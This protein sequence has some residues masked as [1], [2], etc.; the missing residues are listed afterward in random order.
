MA[1]RTVIKHFG[2]NAG[3][4]PLSPKG[5][6][7][8]PGASVSSDRPAGFT[9]LGLTPIDFDSIDP[10]FVLN[11]K[12]RREYLTKYLQDRVAEFG[13]QD[14]DVSEGTP[15]PTMLA[16]SFL[17]STLIEP[18]VI[19]KEET[20]WWLDFVGWMLG[21]P[22]KAEDVLRT[23]WLDSVWSGGNPV[24]DE[25]SVNLAM[26][27][28]DI[29][30]FVDVFVH[31]KERFAEQKEKLVMFTPRTLKEAFLYFKYIVRGD[32]AAAYLGD[33][34]DFLTLPAKP[35]D[36][37][38]P[39]ATDDTAEQ[40]GTKMAETVNRLNAKLEAKLE[41]KQ[42]K[43][44]AP[45][46]SA[47]L[48][49]KEQRSEADKEA[50][51]R[52]NRADILKRISDIRVAQERMVSS[53]KKEDAYSLSTT[54]FSELETVFKMLSEFRPPNVVDVELIKQ[55]RAAVDKAIRADK[56]VIERYGLGLPEG[57]TAPTGDEKMAGVLHTQRITNITRLDNLRSEQDPEPSSQGKEP[58]PAESPTLVKVPAV[59][60]TVENQEEGT[61]KEEPAKTVE[62][63]EDTGPKENEEAVTPNV[64]IIDEP[65]SD[66]PDDQELSKS[67]DDQKEAEAEA[68]AARV[69]E[70]A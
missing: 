25:R 5:Q 32:T 64:S 59:Q 6:P 8:N 4:G 49:E 69:G 27:R 62:A 3:N 51:R 63:R 14:T 67:I 48:V 52:A 40:K 65:G 46:T 16:L 23:P 28:A 15:T 66:E 30:A 68:E 33:F 38:D 31:L 42:A 57:K 18:T 35:V 17:G 22:R 34:D 1:T 26:T 29:A 60:E 10:S 24:H 50:Q 45:L 61:K 9:P 41:P 53:D 20:E 2:P 11:S 58:K 37:L 54:C 70:K 55:V 39:G 47:P 44:P 56:D 43:E 19:T 36:T 12:D 13:V 21:R 7:P